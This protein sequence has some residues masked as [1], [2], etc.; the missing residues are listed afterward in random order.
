MRWEPSPER[1]NDVQ[2]ETS[3]RAMM[4]ATVE[5]FGGIDILVNNAGSTSVA[6]QDLPGG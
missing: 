1:R 4:Q 2:D 5:A 3:V 6:P